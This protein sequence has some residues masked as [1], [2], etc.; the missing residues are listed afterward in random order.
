MHFKNAELA[1]IF[2]HGGA[3]ATEATEVEFS[4]RLCGAILPFS[5]AKKKR[6]HFF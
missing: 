2:Y 3:E 1:L 5:G 4:S 6:K